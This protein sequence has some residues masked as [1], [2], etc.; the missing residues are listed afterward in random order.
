MKLVRVLLA[1]VAVLLIGLGGFVAYA[2]QP[3]IDPI[4]PSQAASFDPALVKRGAELAAIGNCAVCHTAPG[5]AILAGG[6]ALPTPFGTIYATNIT[7]D[8]DTGIGRWSEAAFTRA[9]RKGVDREGNHLYPA[10]PFDHFTHVTDTDNKALYAFLMTRKPIAAEAPANDLPFPLNIR[11]AVAGWKLLFF[12]EGVY[13]P[14]TSKDEIWNRGAYLAEGLG[15]CGA[16]HTPRNSLGAEK[17][18]EHFAG[19]EAEGWS[20]YPINAASLAPIP[21]TVDSLTHYLRDGWEDVHGVARGPMAPVTANLGAVPQEDARAIATYVASVMGEPSPERKARAERLM[22]EPATHRP[23]AVVQ[24]A[25]SQTVPVSAT[26]ENAGAAIYAAACS[27]C[28]DAGRPVPY[29]GLPLRLSTA[30]YG[31]TPANPINVILYGLPAPEG[32]KGP[33]MPGFAG[34]LD[35]DKMAALLAYMRS[36]F[37]DRPAWPDPRKLTADIRAG[38]EATDIRSLPT[39]SNAPANPSK[40]ETAW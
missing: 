27:T 21:W 19:G 23:G 24:T 31:D 22:A 39:G 5:G 10:F 34:V 36:T 12:R 3:T 28:H 9:M 4:E 7:P 6:L 16:C 32:E 18:G 1:L 40:R 37:S 25:G 29:G 33:I 17:R 8:P 26:P 15:H 2:W 13:Q 30:M 20:A 38:H 14:D 35:D 11:M